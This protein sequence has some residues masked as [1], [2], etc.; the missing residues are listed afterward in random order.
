M[1][2]KKEPWIILQEGGSVFRFNYYTICSVNTAIIE[3][4]HATPTEEVIVVAQT[5]GQVFKFTGDAA[6]SCLEQ[7]EAI[8][9]KEAD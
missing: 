6:K 3:T 8:R 1:K 2:N 4:H 5:N 7:W 9:N